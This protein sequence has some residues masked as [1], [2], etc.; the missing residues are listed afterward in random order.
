MTHSVRAVPRP[1][2]KA[3]DAESVAQGGAVR[4]GHSEPDAVLSLRELKAARRFDRP[5]GKEWPARWPRWAETNASRS[6]ASKARKPCESTGSLSHDP[7]AASALARLGRVRA[8]PLWTYSDRYSPCPSRH[9]VLSLPPTS[10][11]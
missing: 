5:G 7:T 8:K 3:I 2:L 1:E 6:Q 10:M 11:L 4:P 9:L